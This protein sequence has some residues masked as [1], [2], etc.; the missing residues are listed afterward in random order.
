MGILKRDPLNYR[1]ITLL[2][3]V[4]TVLAALISKRLMGYCEEKHVLAEE[5]AGFRYGRA[6]VDQIF[7]LADI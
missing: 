6:C 7:I 5:K 3:V 2:S 1:G 4:G